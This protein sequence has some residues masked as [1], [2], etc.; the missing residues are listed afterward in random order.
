[1]H[2]VGDTQLEGLVFE[3]LDSKELKLRGFATLFYLDFF[4]V[5][6]IFSMLGPRIWGGNDT[7]QIWFSSDY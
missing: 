7:K 3:N 6:A 4:L 2:L 5:G 1:M